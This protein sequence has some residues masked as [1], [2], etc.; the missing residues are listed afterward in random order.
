MNTWT[1]P[2]VLPTPGFSPSEPRGSRMI[3]AQKSSNCPASRARRSVSG[4]DPSHG[5]P[6]RTTRVAS[7]SVWES[8]YR[9]ASLTI[10]LS[11]LMNHQSCDFYLPTT[12]TF[13]VK[14]IKDTHCVITNDER[15]DLLGFLIEVLGT[16]WIP[17]PAFPCQSFFCG[18]GMRARELGALVSLWCLWVAPTM[19]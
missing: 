4:P 11:G 2:G 9:I 13:M 19:R 3:D 6:E 10:K 14:V 17:L 5:P 8:M 7:P 12:Q 18:R 16:S 15:Y 1:D